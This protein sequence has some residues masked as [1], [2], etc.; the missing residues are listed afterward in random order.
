MAF[1]CTFP[2]F[3]NIGLDSW[4]VLEA[5]SKRAKI[6]SILWE[7]C[8]N[9]YVKKAAGTHSMHLIPCTKLIDNAYVEKIWLAG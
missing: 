4:G 1:N 6:E 8:A 2:S 3:C 5:G 9:S 7:G